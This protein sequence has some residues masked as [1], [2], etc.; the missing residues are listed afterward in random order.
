MQEAEALEAT[1]A[2]ILGA[3]DVDGEA[4]VLGML[5]DKPGD[6]PAESERELESV[7]NTAVPRRKTKQQRRKAVKL[8][9]EVCWRPSFPRSLAYHFTVLL[10]TRSCGAY[11]A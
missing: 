8:R 11:A 3:R 4:G 6:E 10:E 5:V 7:D 2:R 9:A 1:K